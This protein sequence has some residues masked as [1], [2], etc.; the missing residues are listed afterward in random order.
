M[1]TFFY[2]IYDFMMGPPSELFRSTLRG[3]AFCDGVLERA[4]YDGTW[5]SEEREVRPLVD[6]WLKGD[7][8][9]EEDEISE[10]EAAAY[11]L[12]WRGGRWPGRP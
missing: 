8:D 9:P 12:T 10:S 3:N 2:F 6:R 5:S 11:L 1:A 7:F 4:K